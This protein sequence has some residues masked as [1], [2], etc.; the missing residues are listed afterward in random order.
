MSFTLS[1]KKA[2]GPAKQVWDDALWDQGA[3]SADAERAISDGGHQRVFAQPG[4]VVTIYIDETLGA[5]GG[6]RVIF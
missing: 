2:K 6:R 3:S 1:R 5:I 4:E